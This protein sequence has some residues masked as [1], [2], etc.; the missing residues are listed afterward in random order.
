MTHT[1][2]DKATVRRELRRRRMAIGRE[3]RQQAERHTSGH[4]KT[5]LKRG[6]RLAV[7]LPAGSELRLDGLVKA[8]QQRG[9]QLYLPHI[10]KDQRRMWFVP[11]TPD[12]PHRTRSTGHLKTR[13][14][15]P[16][17]HA[18]QR[19]RA[20]QLHTVIVPLIG[21]DPTGIRMGQGGGFYD[22]SLEQTHYGRTPLKIGVGFACQMHDHLPAE[23][24]DVRLD[25]WVCETG[26]TRFDATCTNLPPKG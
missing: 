14:V 3:Q 9:V 16:R 11:Y 10:E 18:R 21:I 2:Q 15:S 1:H 4:L 23:N 8:T 20:H 5:F 24:H 6:Q 25:A 13:P 26:I 22:T 7:Y 12:K 17:H 19:L